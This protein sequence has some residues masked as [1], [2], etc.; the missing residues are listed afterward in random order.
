MNR[1]ELSEKVANE[2]GISIHNSG[3]IA[4]LMYTKTVILFFWGGD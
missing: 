1:K 2:N 4:Y 3:G